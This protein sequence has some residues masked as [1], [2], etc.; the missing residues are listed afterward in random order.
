MEIDQ[1][2]PIDPINPVALVNVSRDTAVGEKILAWTR[3]T[4]QEA[5]G[6]A[7]PHCTFRE[8]KRL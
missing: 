8:S 4:L 1:I 3:L 7:Y 2:D 5:E 6:H